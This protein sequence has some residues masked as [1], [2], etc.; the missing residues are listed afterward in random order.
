MN[1]FFKNLAIWWDDLRIATANKMTNAIKKGGWVVILIVGGFGVV[2][3]S[4]GMIMSLIRIYHEGGMIAF[5]VCVFVGLV[6]YA[7]AGLG[8]YCIAKVIKNNRDLFGL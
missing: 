8:I 4:I 1:D 2:C 3:A 6:V 7:A 5:G